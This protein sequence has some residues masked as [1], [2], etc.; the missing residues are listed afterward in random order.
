M[1][2]NKQKLQKAPTFDEFYQGMRE[3][4]ML[5]EI[6]A[7]KWKALCEAAEYQMHFELEVAPK[8]DA[9]MT[10]KQADREAALKKQQEVIDA[11]NKIAAEEGAELKPVENEPEEQAQ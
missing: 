7:R 10:K 5:D 4:V 3:E 6:K 8:Y 11:A 1:D 2:K 9:F